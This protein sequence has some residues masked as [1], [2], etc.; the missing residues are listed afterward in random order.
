MK[1]NNSTN[2]SDLSFEKPSDSIIEKLKNE[3]YLLAVIPFMG[4]FLAFLFE[5]GFLTYYEV[6]ITF[7][8][9][10]FTR[11]VTAIGLIAIMLST[12]LFLFEFAI[13][14]SEGS[15]PLKKI[16]GKTLIIII[17]LSSFLILIPDHPEK[18]WF[19]AIA[20][21]YPIIFTLLPAIPKSST[22]NNYWDRVS[23]LINSSKD[24]IKTGKA[25][26]LTLKDILAL[27]LFG[28]IWVSLLGI[29]YAQDKISYWVLN[30]QPDMVLV[31]NYGDTLIF[32]KVLLTTNEITDHL[33]LYK[34]N[35]STPIKMS[36]RE[37]GKLNKQTIKYPHKPLKH[38]EQGRHKGGGQQSA[39]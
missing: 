13:L 27:T 2:V 16:I 6:P 32:K 30:N 11:I 37:L 34:L 17:L 20:A 19:I 28:S 4:S 23:L 1:S 21:C 39:V 35:D 14:I 15:H 36:L 8:Q 12:L 22:S 9:L 3:S 7:I 38:A 10:D 25:N 29:N 24:K 33:E 5:V 26:Q 31:A 18:W